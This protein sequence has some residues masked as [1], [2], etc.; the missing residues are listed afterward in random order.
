MI[1]DVQAV[2]MDLFIVGKTMFKTLFTSVFILCLMCLVGCRG[3]RN[4][5]VY[6]LE[7]IYIE[8]GLRRQS[9]TVGLY[10]KTK[11]C[12]GKNFIDTEECTKTR[13]TYV[14]IKNRTGYHMAMMRYLARISDSR[15]EPAKLDIEGH[16]ICE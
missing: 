10:L 2:Y 5:A 12:N 15:P 16:L 14:T 3:I 13:D 6:N 4:T 11:C 8:Q 1:R 9:A 7:L